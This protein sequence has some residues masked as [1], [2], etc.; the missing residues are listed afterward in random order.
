[1]SA[2]MRILGVLMCVLASFL[3]GCASGVKK[4]SKMPQYIYGQGLGTSFEM[5]KAQA[6]KDLSTNLQVSIK[7]QEQNVTTQRDNTL[8]Q[9]GYS[10]VTAESSLKNLPEVEITQNKKIKNNYEVQVRVD[11]M[12]LMQSVQLQ[13]DNNAQELSGMLGNCG[14]TNIMNHQKFVKIFKEYQQNL[15][16]YRV[17]SEDYSFEDAHLREFSNIAAQLPR[18]NIRVS[19][20]LNMSDLDDILRNELQKFVR[21]DSNA[22]L[23]NV[24]LES[25]GT[26]GYVVSFLFYGCNANEGAIKG[27]RIDT[28]LN[29]KE[30]TNRGLQRLGPIV[31]KGLLQEIEGDS[32]R[33]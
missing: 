4:D 22:P 31:Y 29:A 16:F 11:K 27:I 18:Y 20:E 2:F 30:M 17:L 3:A 12:K 9:S 26:R 21:Q 8:S 25:S 19:N 13:V 24:S 15:S 10:N 6:I 7:Y 14:R 32:T 33:Y 23:A 1:M 5:A 28:H